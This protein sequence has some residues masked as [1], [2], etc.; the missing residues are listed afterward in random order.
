M[1]MRVRSKAF[2]TRLFSRGTLS[3]GNFAVTNAAIPPHPRWFFCFSAARGT[4]MNSF[5]SH[6]RAAEKQKDKNKE[7]VAYAI[8]SPPL[9]GFSDVDREQDLCGLAGD[10]GNDKLLRDAATFFSET[11]LW[12]PSRSL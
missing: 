2:L 7:D 11:V 10:V 8:N 3:A 9:R 6:V 4:L 12:P 5:V 1:L